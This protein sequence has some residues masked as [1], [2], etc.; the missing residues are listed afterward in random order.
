MQVEFVDKFEVV[1]LSF[2][3]NYQQIDDELMIKIKIFTRSNMKRLIDYYYL[4]DIDNKYYS[5]DV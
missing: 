3:L 4:L 1:L 2:V 5:F